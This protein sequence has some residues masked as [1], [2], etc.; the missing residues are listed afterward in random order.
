MAF[1][2]VTYALNGKN[3]SLT[4]P[5]GDI[6]S[7][8]AKLIHETY[9]IPVKYMNGDTDHV[10]FFHTIKEGDIVMPNVRANAVYVVKAA[11][12]GIDVI[13]VHDYSAGERNFKSS[14]VTVVG[15]VPGR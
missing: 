9:D 11:I 1:S 8:I 6:V 4:F 3:V 5:T 15:H 12:P 10:G 2:S 14:A 7:S 13:I